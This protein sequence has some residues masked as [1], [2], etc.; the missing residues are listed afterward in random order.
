[1]RLSAVVQ[2]LLNMPPDGWRV[3]AQ[4]A[5]IYQQGDDELRE[6]VRTHVAF[7]EG[8]VRCGPRACGCGLCY[9]PSQREQT[10]SLLLIP[11]GRGG[12]YVMTLDTT[13]IQSID[14]DR[15]CA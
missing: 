1:M 3:L 12:L 13:R 2:W 15:R 8:L 6:S 7:V 4:V 5:R 14:P 9:T 10:T 11:N